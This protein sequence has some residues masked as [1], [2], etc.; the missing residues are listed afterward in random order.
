MLCCF[1]LFIFPV[2]GNNNVANI[3]S[4]YFFH[5]RTIYLENLSQD[6]AWWANPA[7]ISSINMN[8]F[9]TSNTGL[10][11]GKYSISSVR[12]LFPVYKRLNG[13]VGIT[14]TGTT[15]GRSFTGS[16]QGAQLNSNFS[17]TRP[18]L[19][20]GISYAPPIAGTF[21]GLAIMG[22]ESIPR[23]D[24]GNKT[25]FFFGIG[26]G[27]LSPFLFN[28]I[29]LSF[30]TLSVCHIQFIT[31]W[32]NSAKAGLLIDVN[33]GFILGSIEYGFS[34]NGPVSF[35]RN[36]D[37]FLGYEVIKGDFSLRFRKIAGFLLGFSTDTRNFRDNGSTFHTGIEL[38]RSDVYPYFGGYEIGMNFFATRFNPGLPPHP[39]PTLSL[40]HRLWIGYDFKKKKS[41]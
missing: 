12:L 38:R 34:L 20:V 37:N 3:D 27:W 5:E 36:Q 8:S 21:G 39:S 22:T 17:F 7:T 33:E 31:W 19:E 26:T 32:D 6:G 4:L 35:F 23:A 15:E 28:T 40:I 30:T 10:L 41:S 14:G 1:G 25:Y 9:F 11:G 18:S 24:S 16:S 29:K 13:G 2:R